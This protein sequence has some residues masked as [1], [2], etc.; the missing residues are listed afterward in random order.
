MV[1][2]GIPNVIYVIE[3]TLPRGDPTWAEHLK[4]MYSAM[5]L[6]QVG[7]G[8]FL[9]QTRNKEDTVRYLEQMTIWIQQ[10]YLVSSNSSLFSYR[11]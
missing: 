9:K 7:H 1:N 3:G 2:C 11:G 6:L 4:K 8:F 10:V 5:S